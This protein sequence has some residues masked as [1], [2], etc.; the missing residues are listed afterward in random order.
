M[1]MSLGCHCRVPFIL[2]Q[3][4]AAQ[5]C[6]SQGFAEGLRPPVLFRQPHLWVLVGQMWSILCS[7]SA[8]MSS[9]QSTFL[10]RVL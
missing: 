6:S 10:A 3:T 4:K 5:Q 8:K 2:K 7:D 1:C 9:S